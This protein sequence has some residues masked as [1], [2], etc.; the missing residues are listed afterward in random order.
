M[1]FVRHEPCPE[2]RA[3]G[4]DTAGDN[5]AV[6]S[7]G[8]KWCFSCGYSEKATTWRP[9]EKKEVTLPDVTTSIP[10]PEMQHLRNFLT[11]RE[12][13][14]WYQ[15]SPSNKMIVFNHVTHDNQ[16]FWEGRRLY[17]KQYISNGEKPFLQLGAGNVLVIVE[18]LISAIKVARYY[19]SLPLFGSFLSDKWAARIAR[20]PNIRHVVVWLDYDKK[21]DMVKI[22]NR[23]R[24]L[25]LHATMAFSV[26]DPKVYTEGD[27]RR[28]VEDSIAEIGE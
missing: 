26:Y 16:K 15:Y 4:K 27:I 18:D 9:T 3:I 25:G 10:D 12:I 11:D 21:N 2:C 23:L 17:P 22:T 13:Q 20:L 14:S 24:I 7:N 5:L 8:G 28:T 1:S 19:G 6:Y